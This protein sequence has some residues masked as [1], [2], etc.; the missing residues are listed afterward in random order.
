MIIK[1]KIAIGLLG[2][3]LDTGGSGTWRPTLALCLQDDLAFKRLELLYQ[4]PHYRKA[5]ALTQ[6]ISAVA[7][8]TE[9]RIHEI[10]LK[11]PWDFEETYS[12]LL[13]FAS[14]YHFN[15][16]EEEYYVH[17][18]AGTHV[19]QICLFMLTKA[20]F[21]PGYL[22][23]TSK[24]DRNSKDTKGTHYV[25]DLTLSRYEQIAIKFQSQ[26]QKNV[27]FLKGGIFTYNKTFNEMIAEI[28]AVAIKSPEPI[29]LTGPTGVGKSRL[30]R[31]IYQLKKEKK[32]VTGNF[33]EVNCATIQGD[34]AMS[35]LFGHIKGAYTGANAHRNGLLK[36]ANQGVLFLD[37]IACLNHNE[38]A[39]L[40]RAIEE[41]EFYPMGSDKK[42]MS[43]FQLIAGTNND[44]SK[45]V[46][47]GSFREDLLARINCW[48]FKLPTLRER[49]DDL[50]PNI[51]FELEKA[52]KQL[53]K[54]ITFEKEAYS[55]YLRFAISDKAL[56]DHNFRDLNKSVTRMATLADGRITESIVNREIERLFVGWYQKKPEISSPLTRILNDEQINSLDLFDRLQLEQV[57]KICCESKSL[58]EAGKKLFGQT[59]TQRKII[60]DSDRLRKFFSKFGISWQIFFDYA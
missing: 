40:L 48:A 4:K 51:D 5:Q 35:T 28:E 33:I 58:S 53:D 15:L 50:E 34:G 39:M 59:R 55:L 1:N 10:P 6:D 17:I 47:N 12:V 30:A 13:D 60:N 46:S 22:I 26:K 9:V 29:L 56:W 7:P 42:E 14:N 31:L 24:N 20:N 8:Q 23:Q 44:L 38:Q 25:I 36:S 54:K 16:E 2:S 19:A 43:D 45:M 21:I 18:S 49:L 27:S 3:K 52:T 32:Q 57:I 37:E 41:K 11:H